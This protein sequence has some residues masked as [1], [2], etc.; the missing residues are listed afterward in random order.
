[1]GPDPQTRCTVCGK[2]IEFLAEKKKATCAF[3]GASHE[4]DVTCREGHFVCNDCYHAPAGELIGIYCSATKE[5]DPVAIARTLM[6]TPQLRAQESEQQF[7]IS[8][9]L[10]AAFLNVRGRAEEKPGKIEQ[11]RLRVSQI[12]GD[13][14]GIYGD[15]GAAVGTGIFVSLVTGATPLSKNEWMLT[16]LATA[17]SLEAIALQGGPRC[18]RRNAFIAIL[19]AVE[20]SR[21][22]FG[23]DMPV[24]Q[25]VSCGRPIREENCPAR[26]CPFFPA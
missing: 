10:L 19:S 12:K 2:D 7:L 6:D 5:A 3:C 21:E 9:V 4:T 13:F 26:D 8:A 15:C 25:P 20:F 22:R 24:R 17:K 11:A 18:C 1:M 14:C 16:N 23:I